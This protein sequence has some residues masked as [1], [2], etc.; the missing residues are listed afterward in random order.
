MSRSADGLDP[1]S[2]SASAG[3]VLVTGGNGVQGG[4][5]A[6]RLLQEGFAVRAGVR[7]P[8]RASTL[9]AAGAE[10]V[11]CDLD[12]PAALRGACAGARAMVLS[13]PLE[14]ERDRLLRWARQAGTAA[15]AAGVPLLVFNT[16]GRL[17]EHPSELPGFEVRRA[18]EAVLRGVAPPMIVLRPPFFIDNLLNPAVA[19]GIARDGVVA[20]PLP[21]RL[22]VSWLSVDDLGGYAAAALRHPEL[23]GRAFDVGGPAVLDG[24]GLAGAIA[25]GLGRPMRYL[26]IPPDVFERG[27]AAHM[28]LAVARGI[29]ASYF[30]IA[31]HADEP[32]FADTS[33]ALDGALARPPTPVAAWAASAEA[34]L[35]PSRS[36]GQP[37]PTTSSGPPTA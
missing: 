10:I 12:D 7:S 20:Y 22:R 8:A 32:L 31:Q 24:T 27:L 5:M 1:S 14:W 16:S 18:A 3:T 6:R 13:L 21:E 33:C 11:A 19:T 17:P 25:A 4:A 2:P 35:R 29:A 37:A 15:R 28:P 36:S 30:W 9:A 26:A 23:A 34:A